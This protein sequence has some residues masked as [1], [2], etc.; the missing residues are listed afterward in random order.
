MFD[1]FQFAFMHLVMLG[2]GIISG[3]HP[4]EIP[5]LAHD[6]FDRGLDFF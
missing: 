4:E 1:A 5:V 2:V 6:L 3:Q